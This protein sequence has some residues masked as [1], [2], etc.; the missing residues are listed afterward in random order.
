MVKKIK[1][2]MI[3]IKKHFDYPNY[4]IYSD[5]RIFSLKYNKFLKK[6][7]DKYGYFK[8]MVVNNKN[9]KYYL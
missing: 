2:R 8:I 4:L 5:G 7:I 3:E 6:A 1:T 9:R